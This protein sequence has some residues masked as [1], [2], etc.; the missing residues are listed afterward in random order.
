MNKKTIANIALSAVCLG[1]AV[2]VSAK[3]DTQSAK[4]AAAPVE[5]VAVV[6]QEEIEYYPAT[7]ADIRLDGEWNI[8]NVNGQKVTG[9]ERPFITFDLSQ[10]RIYGNNGC[11]IVN[12][13]AVTGKGNKLQ[14]TGMMST[15]KYCANAPFEHLINTTLDQVR[16]YK[17]SRYGHEYYL[18]LFND[19]GHLIMVLRKHNMDFLNGA[20]RVTAINGQ[21]NSNEGVQFVFDLPEKKIHGNAGCNI[22]NG[23]ITIDPDVTNS[24]QFSN[25]ASTRMMCPDI[26]TETAVLVALEETEKAFAK[27]DDTVTFVNH[28]GKPV[29]QLIRIDPRSLTDGE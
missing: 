29:L 10:G 21:P 3:N 7:S 15:Q 25:I 24:V 18:D 28:S 12:A 11:N 2:S 6:A 17:I 4:S 14:F 19:R 13:D 27:S 8:D 9:E 23:E 16:S 22:I 5:E 26:A 1:C 20:W